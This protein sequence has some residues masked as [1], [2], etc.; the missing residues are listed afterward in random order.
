METLIIIIFFFYV[1]NL[2]DD[3]FDKESDIDDF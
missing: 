1:A 3:I 2:L